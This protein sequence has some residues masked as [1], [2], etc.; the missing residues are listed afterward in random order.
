MWSLH[1][2]F[3]RRI[4]KSFSRMGGSEG[5][6]R[7]R[8]SKVKV[9][10]ERLILETIGQWRREETMKRLM[11]SH[12]DCLCLFSESQVRH[13]SPP[14]I[15]G[16]IL[17]LLLAT[18]ACIM[19]TLLIYRILSNRRSNHH[20]HHHR[21]TLHHDIVKYNTTPLKGSCGGGGDS[22]D[23]AIGGES[24][25]R[26]GGGGTGAG[27]GRAFDHLTIPLMLS[28][29]GL[30]ATGKSAVSTDD[31]NTPSTAGDG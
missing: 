31:N 25:G 12:S 4:T 2:R 22:A 9:R 15:F 19:T 14:I 11:I 17:L 21:L 1:N 20:H 13:L 8:G 16:I 3:L 18:T 26:P 7:L 30:S 29:S 6:D 27:G 5:M 10:M 28:Q 23:G 24:G